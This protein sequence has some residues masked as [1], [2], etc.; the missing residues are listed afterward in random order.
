MALS[1]FGNILLVSSVCAFA[2]WVCIGV[3]GCGWPSSMS[4]WCIETEVFKV[5]NWALNSSSAADDMTAQII[6]EILTVALLL[7]GMLLFSAMN[8]CPPARLRDL[9]WIG[10][11]CCC[12][13]Q[14]PCCLRS[15]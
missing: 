3:R 15:R 14:G 8:M 10:M 2:L 1:A 11:M 6:C 7:N 9:G 4:V 12:G 13:L 5:M